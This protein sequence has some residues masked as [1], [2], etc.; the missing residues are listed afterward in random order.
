MWFLFVITI[1]NLYYKIDIVK[2]LDNPGNGDK[3]LYKAPGEEKDDSKITSSL[4]IK[5]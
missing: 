2:S 3:S 1:V 4:S 5:V